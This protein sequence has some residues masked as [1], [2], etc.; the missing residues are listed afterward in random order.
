MGVIAG[1]AHC[2]FVRDKICFATALND[3]LVNGST[4]LLVRL[5][6]DDDDDDRGSGLRHENIVPNKVGSL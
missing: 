5:L 3:E 2:K 4:Q 1:V 6:D